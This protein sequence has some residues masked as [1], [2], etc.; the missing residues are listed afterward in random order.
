MGIE[1][2]RHFF[3]EPE[4][5]SDPAGR[6]A[7]GA[8]SS[9]DCTRRIL[10]RQPQRGLAAERCAPQIEFVVRSF[11]GGT[12]LRRAPPSTAS[13]YFRATRQTPASR[14]QSPGDAG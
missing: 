8:S 11:Y 12:S 9:S 5:G 3:G 14:K 2:A 13:G 10:R 4:G 7:A 1:A 6:I